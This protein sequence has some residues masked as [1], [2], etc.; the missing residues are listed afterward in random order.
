[1]DSEIKDLNT[2]AATRPLILGRYRGPALLG[3]GGTIL[4]GVAG[5]LPGSPFAFKVPGAWFFGA[6]PL[7]DGGGITS[8]HGFALLSAL[9]CGFAGL[10]LLSRA[11]LM[12]CRQT[13]REPASEPGRLAYVLALWS[14]P[15]LV[16]PPMF[17]NDIYSYAA[18]GELVSHHISPYLYGPGTLGATPF[19]SLAQGV[20]INTPSPYGPLFSGLEGGIVD[21]AG[22]RVLL[23]VVFMRMLA[24]L[25]V[26]L[27]AVFLP[28]LARSYGKDPGLAF[29]LA[30]LNPLV[31][32]FLVGSGHNDALMIGLLVA[33]LS[34]AR[35]RHSGW[36]MLVCALAAAIKIP[37]A[38]GVFAIAWTSVS[39]SRVLWRRVLALA[40]AAIVTV[41][42][43][44]VLGQVFGVGWGW[45]RSLGAS[46]TVTTWITPSDLLAKVVPHL[47]VPAS[48]FLGVAHVTG[49]A[50]AAAVC[51][52]ALRHLP[53]IGLPRALGISLL[54]VVILGPIVQPWYLV[55]GLVP[56]A[57]TAGA[58][59]ASAIV[60]L[61]VSA[62]LVG[63]IG[64]GQ[65]TSELAS[66]GPLYEVLLLL[67]LAALIV[68]PADIG[69][70]KVASST[71]SRLPP[72][73]RS[74]PARQLQRA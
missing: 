59:T 44:E 24:V 41:A 45:T 33:G 2:P 50:A 47:G 42:T 29:S 21:L 27:I 28:S 67:L 48:T 14:A 66:L 15:L 12:I 19:A 11:W 68:A 13:A 43:L 9:A 72:L 63:A 60:L 56:L 38:V 61:S 54:A 35:R 69:V 31:V 36:G 16:A 40:T 4:V 30:V 23:S 17:S 5:S 62:T 57:I 65:L 37:G 39:G 55:W 32:L 64:L 53:T 1:M 51:I 58:R 74:S 6:P 3:F 34:I 71:V 25:G 46:D 20:W 49:Y 10:V 22:H 8:A 52:W 70:D 73:R 18:Q 26:V 7:A